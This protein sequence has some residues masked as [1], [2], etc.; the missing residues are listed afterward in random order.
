MTAGFAFAAY[1]VAGLV[2][3]SSL[4]VYGL[5]VRRLLASRSFPARWGY[6][7]SLKLKT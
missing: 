5:P 3:T 2:E 7:R 1:L 6:C 4:R